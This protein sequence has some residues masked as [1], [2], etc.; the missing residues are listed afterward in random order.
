MTLDWWTLALQTVNVVVLV[1]LLGRFLF[2]PIA[3]IIAER[4]KAVQAGLDAAET[5]RHE[6]EATQAKAQAEIDAMAQ[7]R[8]EMVKQARAEAE[9]EKAR[10]LEEARASAQKVRAEAE[11]DWK[12]QRAAMEHA[13]AGEAAALA[14]DI[15]ARLFERL[16]DSARI[17]GFGDG[18]VTAVADLPEATRA[19]IGADGAPVHLRA[20]RDLTAPE[21]DAIA[22]GLGE[23]LG[24]RVDLVVD[25]DPDLI[26][27]FELIAPHAVVRNDLRA[28][29]GQ[30]KAELSKD[31]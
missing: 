2:R 21:R 13:L 28:D 11:A 27:G 8:A 20:A 12:H 18:L 7:K 10:L 14:V 6:A 16:P 25:P 24:R 19:G 4:Q 26:A 3:A 23:V 15:A 1:W 29:L 30:I 31:D 9:A 22:E 5:A 17:E